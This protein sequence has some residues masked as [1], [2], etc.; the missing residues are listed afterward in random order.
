MEIYCSRPVAEN[1]DNSFDDGPCGG[2]AIGIVDA[3]GNVKTI[4]R[5]D[6]P[7]KMEGVAA[8]MYADGINVLLVTDAD[9]VSKA[10]WLLS[11]VLSKNG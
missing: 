4:K 7:Y 11:A 10:A 3:N 8:T 9:D 5:L 1:T 6:Q 2:S